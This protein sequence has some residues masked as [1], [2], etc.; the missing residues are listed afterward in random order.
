MNNWNPTA[1]VDERVIMDNFHP[2]T[3]KRRATLWGAVLALSVISL[4]G[5]TSADGDS[6]S[7][8][9]ASPNA[10]AE[11]TASIPPAAIPGENGVSGAAG[12][13]VGGI[14]E[15][16]AGAWNLTG[17]LKNSLEDTQNYTVR[18]SVSDKATFSVVNAV[19]I[20]HEVG[21]GESVELDKAAIIDTP[22]SAGL[23]C[24]INVTRTGA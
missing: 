21:A 8:A 6:T 2:V 23:S 4:A 3:G 7:G 15:Y 13:L 9:E 14:C 1:K 17:T 20:T 12:D 18:V 19:V 16:S 22:S 10:T 5:C 11:T 24:V